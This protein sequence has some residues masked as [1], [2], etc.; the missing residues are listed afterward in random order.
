VAIKSILVQTTIDDD[1]EARV[2]VAAGLADR[3]G[4]SL[5]GVCA[6]AIQPIT[7]SGMAAGVDLFVEDPQ[8]IQKQLQMLEKTFRDA[9][10]GKG[11]GVE[12]RGAIGFPTEHTTRQARAADL[13]VTGQSESGSAY[14]TVNPADLIMLAGRPV[15]VV[16]Q[17]VTELAADRIVVAWKDTREARRAVLDSLPFLEKAADV[18]VVAVA[19]RDD[20]EA[21]HSTADVAAFLRKHDV[22]ARNLL[23]DPKGSAADQIIGFA[24][25]RRADLIVAGAYGHSRLREWIFGGV[26]R[27]LLTR[28]PVCCLLSN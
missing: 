2:K 5:I 26:T 18:T 1:N 10:G 20:R 7:T 16:P 11:T 9:A 3:F 14:R 21:T 4:A 13:I 23:L 6:C 27:D 15:L 19:E 22:K 12:W 28:S 17:P 8:D 24:V 25:E